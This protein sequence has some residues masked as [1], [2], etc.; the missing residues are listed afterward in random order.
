MTALR[1]YMPPRFSLDTGFVPTALYRVK[2][3]S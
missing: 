1:P 2:N 3:T